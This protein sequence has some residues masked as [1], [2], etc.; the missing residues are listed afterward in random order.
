MIQLQKL[1]CSSAALGN[2]AAHTSA[3]SCLEDVIQRGDKCSVS[4]V[5]LV[6]EDAE[7]EGRGCVSEILQGMAGHLASARGTVTPERLQIC[8][9]DA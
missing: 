3:R 1:F 9:D 2:A 4:L 8:L 6:E 5:V 7:L